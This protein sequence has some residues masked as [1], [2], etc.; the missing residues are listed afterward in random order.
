MHLKRDRPINDV[1]PP[2]FFN[3]ANYTPG[4][5]ALQRYPTMIGPTTVPPPAPPPAQSQAR[6]PTYLLALQ[7]PPPPPL[8][9]MLSSQVVGPGPQMMTH[10]TQPQN[11]LQYQQNI[12]NGPNLTIRTVSA[13]PPPQPP[14]LPQTF[15]LPTS[16]Q[17]Y[18]RKIEKLQ[19]FVAPLEKKLSCMVAANRNPQQFK[20]IKIFLDL[21]K[22]S[23]KRKLPWKTLCKCESVMQ[24]YLSS[25]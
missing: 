11:M 2:G 10:M 22:S 19:N 13:G 18:K 24:K 25:S 16:S 3:A 5:T 15:I 20:K 1:Q 8:G 17:E 7:P 4:S 12:M 21:I 9:Q 14:A 6:V 23:S